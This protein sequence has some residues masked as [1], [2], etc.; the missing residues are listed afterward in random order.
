MGHKVNPVGFRLS[1]TRDWQSR[2]H[3][4]DEKSYE[5]MLARDLKLRVFLK[6]RL[7]NAGISKI[8]I[9]SAGGRVSVILHSSR[10]GVVFGKKGVEIESL[11]KAV[12]KTFGFEV[13]FNVS[14][15]K[16]PEMNAQLIAEHAARQITD[17]KPFRRILKNIVKEARGVKGIKIQLSGRLGGADIART[18]KD[19]WG[20]IPLHTL[21]ENIE[22]AGVDAPTTYGV[23]GV[24]VWV[25]TKNKDRSKGYKDVNAT[26]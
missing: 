26:A 14:E 2:W 18:E 12:L 20:S 6:K 11:Q 15:V 9:E 5:S 22:Y 17:R 21:R 25:C 19:R 13:S 3:A 24:K 7:K 4:K 10:P 1:L 16:R 8:V 23:C